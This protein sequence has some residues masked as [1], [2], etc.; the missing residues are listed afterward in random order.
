MISFFRAPIRNIAPQA[1][2]TVEQ[3][4]KYITS[5]YA[6]LVTERLRSIADHGEARRYKAEMFDYVTFSGHFR[7]RQTSGLIE[8]SGFL[9]FDIDKIESE[10][11]LQNIKAQLITDEKLHTVLLF[12]SPSG[13]GLK[14]VVEVP[15]RHW[16][17]QITD[18]S[19]TELT[20]NT[21]DLSLRDGFSPTDYTDDTDNFHNQFAL[22]LRKKRSTDDTDFTPA[23]CLL[24]TNDTNIHKCLS[25]T[26][27]SYIDTVTKNHKLLYERIRE[28]LLD[29]YGIVTDH[30]SDIPRPCYLPYDDDAFYDEP[31]FRANPAHPF[32]IV[33]SEEL[34][35]RSEQTPSPLRGTPPN[36][37]GELVSP[38]ALNR[39]CHDSGEELAETACRVPTKRDSKR[40]YYDDTEEVVREI[41]KK[42][43]DITGD[44][45]NWIRIAFAIASKHGAPGEGYFHR[46]SQFHHGYDHKEAHKVY[47]SCLRNNSGAVTI[48]TIVYL[49]RSEE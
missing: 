30:T 4:Y 3:I 32:L 29:E 6:K 38:T 26:N 14:W 33:R 9:C 35:V 49:M 12:R 13:N 2:V 37:G 15:D 46:I 16:L 19:L 27:D 17:T 48:G 39:D 7:T 28:Y 24:P 21:E 1:Q 47:L 31:T 18:Y 34:G 40:G 44:Y 20:E 41:E 10:D 42:R 8:H 11:D 36:L 5:D 45:L 25:P 23:E 43:I 22:L